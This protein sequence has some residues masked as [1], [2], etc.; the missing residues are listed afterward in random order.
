[1]HPP[2]CLRRGTRGGRV[3][4]PR[5]QEETDILEIWV[6]GDVLEGLETILDE[7]HA[8]PP[9]VRRRVGADQRPQIVALVGARFLALY[10]RQ[11]HAPVVQDE[12]GTLPLLSADGHVALR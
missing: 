6:G 4:A 5:C 7:P 12:T 8:R 10:V 11:L 3:V 9:A 2:A 1:M